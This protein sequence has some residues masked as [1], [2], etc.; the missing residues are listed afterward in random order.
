M[1][2]LVKFVFFIIW[3]FRR[4]YINKVI[5]LWYR[6]FELLLGEERYGFGIDIW[7]VGYVKM[8]FMK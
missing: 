5:I 7:S 2:Y 4:L 1:Y 3:V 8:L 6:S